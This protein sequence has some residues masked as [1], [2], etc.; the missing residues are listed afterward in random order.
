MLLAGS[1]A[2]RP[3]GPRSEGHLLTSNALHKPD[4]QH[5]LLYVPLLRVACL[6]EAQLL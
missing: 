2:Q 3:A 6:Q 5:D 1:T 4:L